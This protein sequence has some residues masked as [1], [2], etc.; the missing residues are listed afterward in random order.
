[1]GLR[2]FSVTGWV[3]EIGGCLAGRAHPLEK[4]AANIWNVSMHRL[5]SS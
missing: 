1:M 5:Y 3:A 2:F 4:S